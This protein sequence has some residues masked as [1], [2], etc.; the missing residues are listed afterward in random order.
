MHAN[1]DTHLAGTPLASL[2]YCFGGCVSIL[3]HTAA[4]QL[5][6]FVSVAVAAAFVGRF[7]LSSAS[8][9]KLGATLSHLEFLLRGSCLSVR[10]REGPGERQRLGK[11]RETACMG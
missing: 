4:E 2:R 5:C 6:R 1:T 11:G 3:A 7:R 9:V 8:C 10:K